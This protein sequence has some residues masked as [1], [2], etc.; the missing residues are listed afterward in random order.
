MPQTLAVFWADAAA[1]DRWPRRQVSRGNKMMMR[2]ERDTSAEQ[3]LAALEQRSRT[4]PARLRQLASAMGRDQPLPAHF[5]GD[6][7]SVQRC[8]AEHRRPIRLRQLRLARLIQRGAA[9][10]VTSAGTGPAATASSRWSNSGRGSGPGRSVPAAKAA[11][12]H[13]RIS[14][15]RRRAMQPATCARSISIPMSSAAT[16]SGAIGRANRAS[17]LPAKRLSV[18]R[19]RP[20]RMPGSL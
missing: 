20:S 9:Q 19:I 14:T 7:S 18:A 11:I 4:P 5:A 13:R 6:R 2:L 12:R 10:R 3:K 17:R 8:R 16:S 15:T 1:E